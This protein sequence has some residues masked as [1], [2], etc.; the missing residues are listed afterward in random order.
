MKQLAMGVALL[1]MF[2]FARVTA[3]ASADELAMEYGMDGNQL[4]TV[5]KSAVQKSDEPSRVFTKQEIYNIG[6]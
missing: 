2:V 1:T 3:S 6:F 4:I 5:C